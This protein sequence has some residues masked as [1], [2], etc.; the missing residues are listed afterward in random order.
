MHYWQPDCHIN[1]FSYSDIA[2]ICKDVGLSI[3]SFDLKML[4]NKAGIFMNFKT[5]FD[6]LGFNVGG[7]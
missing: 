7:L 3:N 1:M 6:L 2:R 4:G 5:V